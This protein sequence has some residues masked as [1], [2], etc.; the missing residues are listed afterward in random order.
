MA[1]QNSLECIALTTR[2]FNDN[3]LDVLYTHL[4]EM[5]RIIQ[6]DSLNFPHL[7][8]I[9]ITIYISPPPI[10]VDR[11]NALSEQ[12]HQR[13]KRLFSDMAGQRDT[14]ICISVE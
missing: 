11:D 7:R 5:Y 14:K 10:A 13:L 6:N 3:S 1:Q 2:Q 12:A 8:H 4:E 9:S